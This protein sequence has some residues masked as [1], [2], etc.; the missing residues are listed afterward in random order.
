MG[1]R[2]DLAERLCPLR[3][4]YL[5]E[6]GVQSAEMSNKNKAGLFALTIVIRCRKICEH[7]AEV[8]LI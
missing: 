4:L 5:M 7:L 3:V 2:H 1:D 6:I 8:A